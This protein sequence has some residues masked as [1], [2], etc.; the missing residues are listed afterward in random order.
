[1]TRHLVVD[2]DYGDVID[3]LAERND[4]DFGAQTEASL[5]KDPEFLAELN[6]IRRKK[7][8]PD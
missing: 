7:N 6:K 1:M 2:D 8:A 5:K 4:R 3:I